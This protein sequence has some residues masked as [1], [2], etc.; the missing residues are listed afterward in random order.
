MNRKGEWGSNLP[1]KLE[2][3]GTQGK[4]NH[5]EGPGE[6]GSAGGEGA[7]EGGPLDKK[8]KKRCNRSEWPE[9]PQ[10]E[11]EAGQEA[12]GEDHQRGAQASALGEQDP[13]NPSV[14]ERGRRL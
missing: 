2:V 5:G 11:P 9:D 14:Q 12:P 10:G 4:R 1:A 13:Q 6:G 3:E 7:V 8:R